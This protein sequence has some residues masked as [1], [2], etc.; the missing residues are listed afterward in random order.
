[1][2]LEWTSRLVTFLVALAAAA[3]TP[4]PAEAQRIGPLR[5]SPHEL[6][7]HFVDGCQ[8]MSVDHDTGA[9][10]YYVYAYATIG[11]RHVPTKGDNL[12]VFN[13]MEV[14]V[15]DQERD[16][17]AARSRYGAL[18]A[19]FRRYGGAARYR[20]F[21]FEDRSWRFGDFASA[22]EKAGQLRRKSWM[23]Y[24]PGVLNLRIEEST[25]APSYF[26]FGYRPIY[27]QARAERDEEDGDLTFTATKGAWR[28]VVFDDE[29][30]ALAA[31]KLYQRYVQGYATLTDG[32]GHRV[33]EIT[34]Y[35]ERVGNF[36]EARQR[37]DE[38]RRQTQWPA[39]LP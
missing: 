4:S 39:R 30:V 27:L 38:L 20:D 28:L 22:Q 35:L 2:N 37:A 21:P 24:W 32:M 5:I 1:M 31:K 11:R 25:G 23:S 9:P 14:G 12:L 6:L 18:Q 29:D 3:G 8:A 10:A 34:P 16:L 36:T 33:G 7:N 17:A 15:F 26:L 19:A 13:K